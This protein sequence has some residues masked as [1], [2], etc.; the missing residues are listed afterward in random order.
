MVTGEF[1]LGDVRHVVASADRAAEVLGFQA[2]TDFVDGIRSFASAPLARRRAMTA[3]AVDGLTHEYATPAGP[4][5]VLDGLEL[6]IAAGDYVALVGPSG[7]GKTTLLS[8]LGGLEPCQ[9]GTVIVEGNDLHD[10]DGDR[11]AAF[12][13][14]TVGFVFQHFGLLDA[15]TARENIELAMALD[16]TPRRPGVDR[17][18]DLLR[19]VGLADRAEH[20]PLHLSG[21]ERQ[22]VA[23]ARAL[24]NNPRLLL[25]DEPTGNL[26]EASA[27]SV[28]E[29]LEQRRRDHELTLIVVTHNPVLASRAA[30]ADRAPSR[31]NKPHRVPPVTW[32][33]AALLAARSV[34]RRPGRAV[35]TVLAVSLGAALLTAL[36]TIATTAETKVLDQLAKGG[37]LSGIRV[38][39]A[40][41]DP[42]QV[43]QDNA[44]PGPPR[45]LDDHALEQMRAVPG[46]RAA[47]PVVSVDVFVVRPTSTPSGAP[48]TPFNDELVGVDFARPSLLPLT[49]LFGRLPA[50]NATAEVAVTESYLNRLGLKR[51]DGTRV[52]GTDI[53]LATGRTFAGDVRAADGDLQVRALWTRATVV[54]VVAQEAGS[55]D[56]VVPLAVAQRLRDWTAAS[57][58]AGSSFDLSPSP[59]SGAFVVAN[60]LDNVTTVRAAIT[61]IGYSTSAPEN[62]IASVRR[63]LHVVEIVLGGIGAVALGVA[64]IGIANAM[65]AAVRERHREIGVLKAI[66]ARDRDVQRVFVIE[67]ATIGFV[68]GLIGTV[69]GYGIAQL[70]ALIVNHYLASQGLVT[71]AV[72][73]P[74]GIALLSITGSTAL[75]LIGGVVPARRAARV[76]ARES[77][78]GA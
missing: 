10:L 33:D 21:G 3:V 77:V 11:L 26:D 6:S 35:L 59:Y 75:A 19:Q 18:L 4:L 44:R 67:A 56:F 46:V 15:L 20:R 58:D 36:L 48:L 70:V 34:R 54:G 9:S 52:L 27:V 29:V 42:L 66:G 55:G 43:G 24:A 57:V 12:R 78:A 2:T 23:I 37:P 60:G 47:L 41:P 68:G 25:A 14:D 16:R 40:S 30:P 53:E 45:E 22:R 64:S 39:A 13:R 1:R 31:T 28:I 76:S 50:N 17:A 74:T 49:A 69:L 65:L 51:S 7:A 5:R 62:L 8:L 32:R 72:G 71:V 38:A 63:Y 73:V 61:A